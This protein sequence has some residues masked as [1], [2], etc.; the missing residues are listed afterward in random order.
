MN[1]QMTALDYAYS[2]ERVDS[3]EWILL[4]NAAAE[5][6]WLV[7]QNKKL[8]KDDVR[9]RWIAAYYKS[10][11]EDSGDRWSIIIE[12]PCPKAIKTE[13]AFDRAIDA[14]RRKHDQR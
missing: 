10:I 5:L 1:Q 2:L 6:R 12:G 7:E 3:R 11:S 4:Q 9:Y 13:A 8:K 14:A